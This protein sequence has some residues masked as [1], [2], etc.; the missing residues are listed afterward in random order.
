VADKKKGDKRIE[1]M[2]RM[3]MRMG[4]GTRRGRRRGEE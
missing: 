2:Q 4:M 3:R 1:D